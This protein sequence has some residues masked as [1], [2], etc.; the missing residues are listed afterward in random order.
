MDK[1]L[2]LSLRKYQ[3]KNLLILLKSRILSIS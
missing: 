2:G 1:S 3:I